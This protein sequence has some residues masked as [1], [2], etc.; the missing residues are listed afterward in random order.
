MELGLGVAKG[1]G[2][3]GNSRVERRIGVKSGFGVGV[4]ERGCG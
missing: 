1:L 4:K 2:F 3:K